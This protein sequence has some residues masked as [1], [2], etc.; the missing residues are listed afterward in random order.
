MKVIVAGAG[1]AGSLDGGEVTGRRPGRR[2]H[3]KG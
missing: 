2:A 3:R 1:Y